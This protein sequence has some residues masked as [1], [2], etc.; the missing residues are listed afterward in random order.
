V[1]VKILPTRDSLSR[2]NVF[3]PLECPI[4]GGEVEYPTHIF[5]QCIYA[6]K[7]WSTSDWGRN[8]Y[9]AFGSN[10]LDWIL[11]IWK[12]KGEVVFTRVSVV[13]W[14]IWNVCNSAVFK[15]IVK[16]PSKVAVDAL[17]YIK[18]FQNAQVKPVHM[19]QQVARESVRWF[20]P[21]EGWCK[22]NMDGA[23][24][25]DIQKV[26][27]GVVIR[28]DGGEF[29]GVC[30]SCWTMVRMQQMQKLWQPFVLLSLLQKFV[31]LR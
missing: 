7:V 15:D 29:L 1:C 27:I 13:L 9:S 30:V 3:T 10:I 14:S 26:G 16:I 8:L 6:R 19:V 4:C 5:H 25:A 31:P 28:N 21:V 17:V 12:F 23:V 24:F 20:A 11:G 2:R 22:V 18:E